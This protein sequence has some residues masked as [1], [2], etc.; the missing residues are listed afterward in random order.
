MSPVTRH[1]SPSS[2]WVYL[3]EPVHVVDHGGPEDGPLLVCVHGLGGSS[4][5]WAALA[6]LLTPTARV[7]AL[8]LP[9]FGLTRTG[10]Q[11]VSVQANQRT[12]HRFLTEVV[13]GPAILMGNSMGGLISM[14]EASAHPGEVAG[15]VLVDPALPVTVRGRPDPLVT[16]MF[17][18]YAVPR[19]GRRAVEARRRLGPR[20]VVTDMLQLS[21]V[22][23]DRVPAEVVEQHVAMAASRAEYPEV[24]DAM[25]E[26]ARSLLV[27]ISRRRR[28]AAMLARLSLP[29]LLLHGEEDRLVPLPS[30]R[31]AAV[32]KPE[33]RFEVARDVGHV[34]QLEAPEWT[35]ERVADWLGAEGAR[36][37]V[38][39]ARATWAQPQTT[40]A[41]Q[42]PGR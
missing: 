19:L 9:G 38:R 36:A 4:V 11:S 33:W 32:A 8:D 27:V 29:V 17:A 21:C 22:D 35:A 13:Q 30:A 12:L 31:A 28:F 10:A 18:L 15:L 6:P 34:P 20:A 40:T 2:H 37:A 42:E 5:N 1:T 41:S 14:M 39:A 3:G 25:I 23:P 16:A 26:A 24:P 7:V